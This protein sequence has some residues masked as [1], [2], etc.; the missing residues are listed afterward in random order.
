MESF[1]QD[2][3][4]RFTRFFNPDEPEEGLPEEADNS[5]LFGKYFRFL[6]FYK[7][8]VIFV[9]F[10]VVILFIIYGL[11]LEDYV[12]TTLDPPPGS[13]AADA[14]DYFFD[15]YPD[16]ETKKDTLLIQIDQ[17]PYENYTIRDD[18]LV[19]EWYD[20]MLTVWADLVDDHGAD[21]FQEWYGY[22]N[23]S[24]DPGYAPV[25]NGFI[26]P[27]ED[28]MIVSL[29][30][31]KD[32]DQ[33]T[34]SKAQRKL[35][36]GVDDHNPDDSIYTAYVSGISGIAYDGAIETKKSSVKIDA[37]CMPL[38]LCV[39]LYYIK[40]WR[41]LVLPLITIVTTLFGTMC[42]LTAIA[43]AWQ[44]PP[45]FI[46]SVI[47]VFSIALNIDYSLFLLTR[48]Y[49]ERTRKFSKTKA[50]CR[51]VMFAG[52]VVGMSG[53]T[54]FLCSMGMMLFP[55]NFIQMTGLSMALVVGIAISVNLSLVPCLIMSFP[56]YFIFQLCPFCTEPVD[57]TKMEDKDHL[58]AKGD[59]F[60][61]EYTGK[62][63]TWP[64]NL[65]CGVI[66]LCFCIPVGILTIWIDHTAAM[67]S[68]QPRGCYS[69]DALDAL[70]DDFEPGLIA[71]YFII[72]ENPTD[73]DPFY[74]TDYLLALQQIS[75]NVNQ[76]LGFATSSITS[77]LDT[78]LTIPKYEDPESWPSCI[79]WL[80]SY[81]PDSNHTSPGDPPATAE[82]YQYSWSKSV[83]TDL[84]SSKMTLT[85]PFDPTS[86]KGMDLVT[87]I[88]DDVLTDDLNDKYNYYLTNSIVDQKDAADYTFA[89]FPI[90][91]VITLAIICVIV[92][93]GFKTAFLS[94]RY[95]FTLVIPI[96]FIFG[97]AMLV[98][99]Y[100]WLDWM[101]WDAVDSDWGPLYWFA[102]IM[103]FFTSAG[104]ALDYDIFLYLR[105][106]EF[107]SEGCD[108]KLSCMK[109]ADETANIITAAGL[110]MALVF[111]GLVFTATPC[112]NQIGFMLS[113]SVIFDTFVTRTILVPVTVSLM[114]EWA[115][116]P[117][118]H[119]IL[120]RAK[121]DEAKDPIFQN[122]MEYGNLPDDTNSINRDL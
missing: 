111:F 81:D 39:L 14:E 30:E 113:T 63:S 44:E 17:K 24:D 59:T 117:Q 46:T 80:L 62:I 65:G 98:Y 88:R 52:H 54:L 118:K 95:L 7:A 10:V 53:A 77:I 3:S 85:A 64:F 116:Y 9:W 37:I 58:E 66:L 60:W 8:V 107:R 34:T 105:I 12:S 51:S 115:W 11:D 16:G 103:A 55:S 71:P 114:G 90:N 87:D 13:D 75:T 112:L 19:K 28:A 84:R 82:S 31:D 21:T 23:F 109:A 68:I 6:Y 97:L 26:S 78:C 38:A 67:T 93:L 45:S 110:I 108:T 22:Y 56:D 74:S 25:A 4:T 76:S 89:A 18:P 43:K 69:E 101:G 61:Y 72:V 40:S 91:V 27:D 5:T 35:R 99:Q 94:F 92:S 96:S 36:D 33:E 79:D 121:G 1:T 70:S 122:K 2:V 106:M 104:L 42:I 41:F 48:F 29:Q 15:H 49:Q 100:G 120:Y 50:L 86:D 83:G 119:E 102:P 57:F 32:M 47:E 20:G 73:E